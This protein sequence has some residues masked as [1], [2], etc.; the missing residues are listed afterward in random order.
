MIRYGGY[1]MKKT[2]GVII[3]LIY[4]IGIFI[5][6]KQN[7]IDNTMTIGTSIIFMGICILIGKHF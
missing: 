4:L 3:I 7:L 6:R 2:V 1:N 5:L